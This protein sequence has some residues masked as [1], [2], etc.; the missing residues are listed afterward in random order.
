MAQP[1]WNTAAGSLGSYPTGVLVTVQLSA[2]VQSPATSLI[3]I[4][5]SG[6]LPPGLSVNTSGLISGIPDLVTA[7]TSSTFTIRV[8][9]NLGNLRDRTFS[10]NISGT[11]IPKFSTPEGSLLETQDSIW[12]QLQISFT[13]PDTANQVF[14]EL[15][16]GLLP[17]GLE[18]NEEGLIRGYPAPPLV[19]TSLNQISITATSTEAIT[20]LITCLSTNGF[21]IGRPVNFSGTVFGGIAAST[22][23]YIKT[24]DSTTSFTISTTIGGSVFPLV[25]S[26]G[27]MTAVLPVTYVGAPTIVT[28]SFTLKL[29]SELGGNTA[30]YSITVINQNTPVSQGGPGKLSNSRIPTLLNTRP[31]TITVN[32]TDPYFGYYVLP[33][34]NPG[35]RANIGTIQSGNYFA[36]KA[37]GYDFDGNDLVYSFSGLPLGLVGNTTTGWI[38]G[39]PTLASIGISSYGFSISTYK[40]ANPTI[41]SP[42][43][44]FSFNLSN[45][46]NEKITWVTPSNLGTLF[47]GVIST[48]SVLATSDVPL[49]YRVT[50]GTL[51]PNI[52]LS[53]NGELIGR[54]ADQPT[55]EFLTQGQSTE[56]TFT[57]E[58]YSLNYSIIKSSRTFSVSVLQEY[59]KPTDIL[60]IKAA[61]SI[62]DRLIL[63]TLL[64]QDPADAVQLIPTEDL[65]RPDDLYFGK[66]SSVVYENAYG[67]YAS[68][69]NQYLAAVTRNHY[70]RNITLGEIKTA[71]AKNDAGEEIYEVVYSEVIDNLINPYGVSINSSIFWERPIDLGLGPWYSSITDIYTSYVFEVDGTP[72]YYTSLSPGYARTLYPNSLPNMRNRVANVLGQ[73]YDSRLLPQWMTSQ[74]ADGNTL[75]YTQAWVICYTKPGFANQIK[76]NINT[77]WGKADGTKYTLNMI[78]FNIDRFTVDKSATYNYDNNIRSPEWT[79]TTPAYAWTGLPSATPVPNPLDSKDFYVLFPR[80]T[81]LPDENQY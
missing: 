4:L 57:I 42:Y 30:A 66:A 49:V 63:D 53:T 20:N 5:L 27:A 14:V 8:T 81:I 68:S 52:E 2:S 41:A 64:N 34:V 7:D 33:P 43:F 38:T 74:Q 17:P 55:S 26:S 32:D 78:N 11:A 79:S 23:Y 25:N 39:T 37:I 77:L 65:Y 60:Y 70:W 36:F 3:Y 51:P 44:N 56:F 13:N 31:L 61:P 45:D 48:L 10:M 75:G 80:E 19:N 76:N 28:Y 29:V 69:I 35:T 15:K 47:N 50:S 54:V 1:I 22:T 62:E 24:I 6:A 58:A 40:L 46:I 67:I 59:N 72:T 9:D 21:V 73:E 18:I 71:V 12:T 16:E